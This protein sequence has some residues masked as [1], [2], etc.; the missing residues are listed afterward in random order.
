MTAIILSIVSSVVSA[1]LVF[2][3]QGCIRENRKLKREK[4]EQHANEQL[5]IARGLRGILKKELKEIYIKYEDSP[6][7]PADDF[8]TWTDM[9]DSY[10]GLHGNGTFKKMDTEVRKKHIV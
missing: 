4:Q 8:E 2:I 1:M 3:L 10:E 9:F 6:T 5:S 7:I